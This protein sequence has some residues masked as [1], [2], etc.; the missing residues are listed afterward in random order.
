MNGKK[1]IFSLL[2]DEI[3]QTRTIEEKNLIASADILPEEK[4]DSVVN[5]YK[6]LSQGKY[7]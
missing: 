7:P 2:T 1:P 4:V 5:N 6:I 3:L